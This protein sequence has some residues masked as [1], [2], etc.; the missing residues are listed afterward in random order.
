MKMYQ[1]PHPGKFI[2][3]TY[4]IPLKLSK[5]EIA[6]RLDVSPSTF[7]RVINAKADISPEM[8][9]RLER[10][11]NRTAESWLLMQDNYTLN[12][13]R[14]NIDLSMLQPVNMNG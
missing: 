1:P 8:A 9:L 10:L 14:K 11:F 5:A 2:E 12:N 3:E 4:L 7:N 13:I 6:R